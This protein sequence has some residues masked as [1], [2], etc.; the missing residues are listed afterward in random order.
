MASYALSGLWC[1]GGAKRSLYKAPDHRGFS[2]LGKTFLRG[3]K[4][5]I[6]IIIYLS[7]AIGAA[8][9]GTDLNQCWLLIFSA[10]LFLLAVYVLPGGMTYNAAYDDSSKV[11]KLEDE[12][13]P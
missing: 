3:L 12:S 5:L 13:T 1:F 8:A 6:A 9:L 11:P 7:P 2:P 4:A 10:L